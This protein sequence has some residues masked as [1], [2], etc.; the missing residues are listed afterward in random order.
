M[1]LGEN[2]HLVCGLVER[3]GEPEAD[4]LDMGTSGVDVR[5]ELGR[6]R[7]EFVDAVAGLSP[8]Q[9]DVPSW[10]AGWRVRDVVGHLVSMRVTG[11]AEL[12]WR[13]ARTG[14][15]PDRA[16]DRLARQFGDRPEAQLLEQLRDAGDEGF[17]LPGVPAELGLGDLLVHTADALRPLGISPDPPVDDVVVVLDV[18]KRW[19]RRVFHA[20]P[21]Q[22]VALVATDVEWR[23]GLGPEVRGK[24]IDL[25]LLVANR[26]Q[27]IGCLDGPGVQHLS[28]SER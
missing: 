18:Y 25:L 20:L 13:I 2:N 24:A 16:V 14:F 23:D 27:V 5:A 1:A 4:C 8:D 28:Q 7:L 19:G 11:Q 6:L 9:W 12:F 10:C 3:S 22:G 15:R 21:H 26:R 17:R